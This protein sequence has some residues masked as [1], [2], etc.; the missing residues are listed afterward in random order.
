MQDGFHNHHKK[1][2]RC[3]FFYWDA[4][5]AQRLALS[6]IIGTGFPTMNH[7]RRVKFCFLMPR[8]TKSNW[9]MCCGPNPPNKQGGFLFGHLVSCS[10]SWGL[11]AVRSRTGTTHSCRTCL[12]SH[13]TAAEP[14]HGLTVLSTTQMPLITN[15]SIKED[16]FSYPGHHIS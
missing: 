1:K 6:F 4:K 2:K 15:I 5:N 3:L 10:D 16:V 13:L 9:R 14:R 7:C 8:G 12:T 11:W